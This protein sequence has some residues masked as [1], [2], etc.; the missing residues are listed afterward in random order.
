VF[1]RICYVTLFLLKK[2]SHLSVELNITNKT[3]MSQNN[4]P[5]KGITIRQA[6]EWTAAW[7]SQNPKHSKAFLIPMEAIVELLKELNVLESNGAGGHTL[8]TNNPLTPALRAYL[9]V[10]PDAQGTEEEKLV[11][12]GAVA[13]GAE[14]QDQVEE[15]TNKLKVTLSGSGAFDFTFPCPRYCDPKSPL[16]HG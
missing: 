14:Y 1:I 15:T 4:L 12:V 13:V 5:E 16:N 7:Q 6:K 8:N 2:I 3:N 11:L 10:G 9:A